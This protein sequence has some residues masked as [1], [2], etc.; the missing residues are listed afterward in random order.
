MTTKLVIIIIVLSIALSSAVTALA[1]SSLYGDEISKANAE[2]KAQED[3]RERLYEWEASTNDLGGVDE[4]RWN[5]GQMKKDCVYAET[6]GYL[7]W[8]KSKGLR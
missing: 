1:F 8:C 7:E 5:I 2:A 3:L 6:S 4:S